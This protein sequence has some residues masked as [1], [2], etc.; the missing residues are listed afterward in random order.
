MDLFGGLLPVPERALLA[1]AASLSGL[2]V[3]GLLGG[4][5]YFYV[6][7]FCLALLNVLTDFRSLPAW[8]DAAANVVWVAVI[9]VAILISV[10]EWRSYRREDAG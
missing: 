8:V 5:H 6:L 9:P 3:A 4:G 1:L 7:L 10:Q 2:V